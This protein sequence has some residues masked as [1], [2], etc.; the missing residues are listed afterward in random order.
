VG[1]GTTTV[2]ATYSNITGN[3]SITVVPLT[4]TLIHR[5]D[6]SSGANDLVGANNGTLIGLSATVANGMLNLAPSS[7]FDFNYADFGPDA[8]SGQDAITFEAW[9]SFGTN[10]A[11]ARLF[12]FGNSDG[13]T[14]LS[15]VMLTPRT[16]GGNTRLAL[17]SGGTEQFVDAPG[18]LDSKTN[19]HIVAVLHPLAGYMKLYINGVLA[20]QN[21][22]VTRDLR[23]VTNTV[24]YIGQSLFYTDPAAN[25]SVD[26]FRIYSGVLFPTNV[27]FNAAA[28]PGAVISD[29][30]AL[31]S[32]T[33]APLPD[34]PELSGRFAQ[35]DVRGNF[36]NVTN[37]PLA[38]FTGVTFSSSDTNVATVSSNGMVIALNDGTATITAS[39][40]TQS[41][42]KTVH[43]TA[44]TN[45]T[46]L[47]ADGGSNRVQRF[48]ATGYVGSLVGTF[49]EGTYAGK[50]LTNPISIAQDAN[51]NVYVGEGIDGGRLLKFSNTGELVSVLATEGVDFTGR[52]DCLFYA[53]DGNLYMSV[54]FTANNAQDRVYKI[55]LPS[56]TVS[57]FIDTLGSGI[58]G[59]YTLTNPR[60]LAVDTNGVLYVSSRGGFSATGRPIL[61]F[62]LATGDYLGDLVNTLTSPSTLEYDPLNDR[63]LVAVNSIADIY[64]VTTNGAVSQV[65]NDA[66]GRTI[67]GM[68]LSESSLYFVDF[69]RPSLF[70]VTGNGTTA[71]TV[72]GGLSYNTGTAPGAGLAIKA[73]LPPVASAMG[74]QRVGNDVIVTWSG[75]GTLQ[76]ATSLTGEFSDVLGAT[77]PHTN[78]ISGGEKYFRV[79]VR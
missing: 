72:A 31:L 29:P 26:E 62:N 42:S 22:S 63:V 58:G 23:D 38:S 55:A 3:V 9:A 73:N 65:F 36:A 25:L 17:R 5:Y 21:L 13:V 77:S 28:G 7:Q 69:T 8:I 61:K 67:R 64:G 27:A 2:S 49:A 45:V 78:S 54:S 33:L 75:P 10:Y 48:E 18:S 14:A 56:G 76:T 35:L 39:Y 70:M 20:G 68:V 53:P 24:S 50:P 32:V 30:G 46:I 66:L 15:S 4:T 37:V 11:W 41:D 43:V 52:P 12:D 40:L 51:G 79:K 1:T 60:G 57:V 6:F 71:A 19:Q 74:I 47:V 59:S 34:M 44:L 16:S